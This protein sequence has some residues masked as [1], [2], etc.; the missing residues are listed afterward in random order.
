MHDGDESGSELSALRAQKIRLP[1]H[2]CRRQY[3]LR[4]RKPRATRHAAAKVRIPAYRANMRD[5]SFRREVVRSRAGAVGGVHGQRLD[6]GDAG[7]CRRL[8]SCI[9]G[10]LVSVVWGAMS[11]GLVTKNEGRPHASNVLP[12]H[13][14]IRIVAPETDI[15]LRA[16]WSPGERQPFRNRCCAVGMRAQRRVAASRSCARCVSACSGPRPP[17]SEVAARSSSGRAVNV[18]APRAA[19]AGRFAPTRITFPSNSV[20]RRPPA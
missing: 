5:A 13:L 16:S 12:L 14:L 18:W 1:S 11:A 15:A 10:S 3:S 2:L 9:H 6:A 7:S 4:S 17:A 20:R 19:A 8:G